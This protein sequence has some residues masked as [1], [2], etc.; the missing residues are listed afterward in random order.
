L[1]KRI[2]KA[3]LKYPI[4]FLNRIYTFFYYRTKDKKDRY[5][6]DSM[7]DG[8]KILVL[9][10]HVDD[11]TIGLGGTL[12]KHKK[13]HSSMVLL[14]LTDGSGSTSSLSE[15]EV[16]RARK[17]EGERV[18]NLYGF[19]RLY[20]LDEKDGQL[21]SDKEEL[22][23]NLV[24]ILEKENPDIIYTPFLIDGH[25]DHVETTKSLIK[26]LEKW[27][28]E[29][30]NIYMYEVNCPIDPIIV[31]CISP[32]DE[33]LYNGKNK[34]Y[35]TFSSQWAMDFTVFSLLDRRKKMF[36]NKEYGAEIF[37]KA[38]LESAKGILKSLDE[39]G[40]VPE[41]FRQLSSEYT[42]ILSF[43]QGRKLKSLYNEEVKKV[44]D[45]E[46]AKN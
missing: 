27:N 10:P 38:N 46:E 45:M 3:I 33:V 11:E 13:N 44:L 20:F 40:F 7:M 18:K 19:N 15:E 12:F 1:V 21:S 4:L 8:K 5:L 14:Y 31:N 23:K 39:A 34:V 43:K 17:E 6:V 30:E 36:L 29:F 32:M 26:A 37:V 35:D 25:K 42:L 22:I 9:A 41:Q 16:I 28:S 2:I 24:E